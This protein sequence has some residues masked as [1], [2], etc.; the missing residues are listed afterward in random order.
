LSS[1]PST[2][3]AFK[4]PDPQCSDPSASLAETEVKREN[5]EGNTEV[6]ELAGVVDIQIEYSSDWLCNPNIGSAIKLTCQNL[7]Q[8]RF[9]LISWN[10]G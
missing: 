6:P 5:N 9:C 10:I 4:T 8:C 1:A 7:G 2:T 3:A